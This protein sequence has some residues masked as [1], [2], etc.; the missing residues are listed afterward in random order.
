MLA[1]RLNPCTDMCALLRCVTPFVKTRLDRPLDDKNAGGC[2]PP[3]DSWRDGEAPPTFCFF[4]LNTHTTHIF[5]LFGSYREDWPAGEAG[6]GGHLL[7]LKRPA[8]KGID[9]LGDDNVLEE[10]KSFGGN[11][12]VFVNNRSPRANWVWHG[13]RHYVGIRRAIQINYCKTKTCN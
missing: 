7:L 5:L 13:L 9:A 4:S 3:F 12:V 11:M 8:K 2:Q 1:A 6:A 10:V